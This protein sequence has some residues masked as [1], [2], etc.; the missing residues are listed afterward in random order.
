MPLATLKACLLAVLAALSAAAA[1]TPAWHPDA[2]AHYLDTRQAWW[3]AWPKSHRDLDTTCVSCHT[4]LPYAL[5]RPALRSALKES[6]PAAPERAL[7]ASIEKRV[8]HWDEAEPFYKETS[9]L[10]KPAES[11]ATEAI[12]NALILAAYDARQG[13][14]R[15]ITREALDRVWELQLVSGSWDWL[16]F[17]NAPWETNDSP[18]WGT[19]LAALAIGTAPDPYRDSPLI[20]RQIEDMR[21]YLRREYTRQPLVNRM[22][23]LWTSSRL[24][25]LISAEDRKA[26]LTEIAAAQNKDGGWPLAGNPRSDGYPTA[27]A[28]LA[29]PPTSPAAERGR[30]WLLRN[31]DPTTGSWPSWSPNKER[32]PATDVGKF[33]SDAATGYAILAL[34]HIK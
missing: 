15:D 32:D 34:E 27:L 3:Q 25:G 26:L 33:M 29:L 1:D 14:L 5:A 20:Q 7:L 31:Q 17:H 19:T 4:V 18:Y 22:F 30:A 11:R 6:E 10:T 9:G 24:P 23:L 13:H 21:V 12:L 2:A 16:N 8:E 28:V